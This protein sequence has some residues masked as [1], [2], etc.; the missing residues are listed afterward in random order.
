MAQSLRD[1]RFEIIR[2]LTPNPGETF[3]VPDHMV[4]TPS[5]MAQEPNT[6]DTRP[7]GGDTRPARSLNEHLFQLIR[8]IRDVRFQLMLVNPP[9][10]GP[11]GFIRMDGFDGFILPNRPNELNE[12]DEVDSLDGLDFDDFDLDEPV[13]P[14]RPSPPREP[15]NTH[16]PIISVVEEHNLVCVLDLPVDERICCICRLGFFHSVYGT[17]T[18][19]HAR[20]D[21]RGIDEDSRGL[22]VPTKLPCGHIVGDKCIDAW[23]TH[24]LSRGSFAECPVCRAVI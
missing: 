3:T 20:L 4:I 16:I 21:P 24:S 2:R 7:N 11:D 12:P 5:A 13:E 23:I 15:I 14:E 18:E 17:T 1:T 19:I 9:V 6:E 10:R 22:C 8:E